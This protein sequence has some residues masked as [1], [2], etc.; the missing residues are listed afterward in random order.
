MCSPMSLPSVL[1]LREWPCYYTWLNVD[2]LNNDAKE[3]QNLKF[4]NC[5]TAIAIPA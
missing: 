5:R 1:S 3:L 4:G 2:F